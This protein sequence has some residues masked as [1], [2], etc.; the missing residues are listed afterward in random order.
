[1]A[2]IRWTGFLLKEQQVHTG[3]TVALCVEGKTELEKGEDDQPLILKAMLGG[4][5]NRRK[6]YPI[7]G[8]RWNPSPQLLEPGDLSAISIEGFRPEVRFM[9]LQIFN[10]KDA[11]ANTHFVVFVNGERLAHEGGRDYVYIR[12]DDRRCP[13][14]D[15]GYH[16]E[17]LGREYP[18]PE[19]AVLVPISGIGDYP[20][21]K[22]YG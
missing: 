15:S 14:S 6:F 19:N 10:A 9:P 20:A 22:R 12:T 4:I 18:L 2:E 8:I 7:E 11:P 16:R 5:P 13:L 21:D 3:M 1:M 17:W